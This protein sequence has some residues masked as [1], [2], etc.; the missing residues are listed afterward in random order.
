MCLCGLSPLF[1]AETDG[2]YRD[3][4]LIQT[5]AVNGVNG[6]VRIPLSG[7]QIS[8]PAVPN[9]VI[10]FSGEDA[11]LAWNPITQ[12]IGG[13]P[14]SVTGYEV[15]YSPTF[16]GPYYYHGFTADTSYTHVRAVQFAGGMYYQVVAYTGPLSVLEGIARGEEMR[17]VLRT[18]NDER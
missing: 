7:T 11:R 13:C 5:D 2:T 15:F 6:Y 18:M 1:D 17:A 8:T 3:T 10:T 12:S 16:G 9:V 14:V 4:L